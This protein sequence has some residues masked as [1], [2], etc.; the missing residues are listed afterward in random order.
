MSSPQCFCTFHHKMCAG[1]LLYSF[2]CAFCGMATCTTLSSFVFFFFFYLGHFLHLCLSFS[3]LKHST[4]QPIS[5]VSCLF[6]SIPYLITLLLNISNLF[7]EM[8]FLFSF[9][10]LFLQ[11]WARCPNFLQ[12]QQIFPFLPSSSALNLARVCFSLS[13]LL[14]RELYCC[15]DMMLHLYNS[16]K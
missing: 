5:S 11:F 3:Y 7:W 14:I 6:S 4:I 1:L 12:Y 16:M 13:K 10:S 2:C 15:K 9:S 8:T